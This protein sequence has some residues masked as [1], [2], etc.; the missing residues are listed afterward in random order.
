MKKSD[1]YIK[2]IEWSEDDS[3]YVGRCP[4][5]FSG[6]C[7]GDNQ[8]AVFNELCIIIEEVIEMFQ[9]EGTPLPQ[10]ILSKDIVTFIRNQ[11]KNKK[12]V[13]KEPYQFPIQSDIK[14]SKT[15][16]SKA[17]LKV[18][19][20]SRKHESLNVTFKH[21]RT[22]KRNGT[23]TNPICTENHGVIIA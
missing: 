18:D 1:K 4:E 17:R 10:P 11:S 8:K 20:L 16:P 12:S 23:P 21:S 5:L 7:H 22:K 6:G 14:C 15:L 9:K 13:L 3:C 2:I 19:S